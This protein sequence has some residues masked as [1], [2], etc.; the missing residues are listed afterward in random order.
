MKRTLALLAL[1]VTAACGGHTP[2]KPPGPVPVPRWQLDVQVSDKDGG[3]ADAHLEILDGPNKSADLPRTDATGRRLLSNLEQSGFTICASRG[4]EY[5]VGCAGVTLTSSQ[6]VTIKL[7]RKFSARHGLVRRLGDAALQDDDGAR[8]FVGASLFWAPPA[9]AKEPARLDQNLE[10]LAQRGADFV[11]VL[12]A[13]GSPADQFWGCCRLEISNPQWVQELE[14]FVAHA[15]AKGLRT[16]LTVFGDTLATT[17]DQRRDIID[18]VI[19]ITKADPAR[20]FAIEVA[21]EGFDNFTDKGEARELAQR[22]Q[23]AVPNLVAVTAPGGPSCTTEDAACFCS[24][25]EKWYGGNVGSLLTFHFDRSWNGSGGNWRPVRQPWRGAVFAC[26]GTTP[27]W[28]SNEPIGP[29][30]SVQADDDPA[31]RG[32]L[33]GVT[34]VSRIPVDV[35]HT[36]AGVRGVVDPAR[37]RPANVFEEGN[38]DAGLRAATCVRDL[39]PQD[40]PNW[41]R[42]G[43]NP[44]SIGLF[45]PDFNAVDRVYCAKQDTRAAC[46][47]EN[48]HAPAAL[49]T[50][51]A[52]HVETYS[53]LDCHL[54]QSLDLSS[55]ASFTLDPAAPGQ[56]LL[57]H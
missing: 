35:W 23:A 16:E 38:A 12:V 37:G 24:E 22:L 50:L 21:N 7:F 56:V 43:S 9:L 39:L 44:A 31:R 53:T 19:N 17:R 45:Q 42:S 33:A 6:N 18:S 57:V 25:I 48:I 52:M 36:G 1:L 49:K 13:V 2:P 8:L 34:F 47:A 29:H 10:W 14:A 26:P 40:L 5:S 27:V 4:D 11:R 51:R 32:A 55:G 54:L 46:T 28:S 20:V 15:Y 41:Q 3:V 30:S